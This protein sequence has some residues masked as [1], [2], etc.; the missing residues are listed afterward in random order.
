LTNPIR[1]PITLR[2][3][4]HTR[5]YELHVHMIERSLRRFCS[6]APKKGVQ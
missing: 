4:K 6:C 2:V 3:V 1:L 5:A